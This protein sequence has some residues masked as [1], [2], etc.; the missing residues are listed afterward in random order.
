MI[1]P[2]QDSSCCLFAFSIILL[3]TAALATTETLSSSGG[4]F[5]L[6]PG[7]AEPEPIP[8]TEINTS[9]LDGSQSQ[10]SALLL[11]NGRND[12]VTN[13]IPPLN[14]PLPDIFP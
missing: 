2:T 6:F 11:D 10:E 1:L 3:S 9:L 8:E 14:I 7:S 13:V 12:G 5:G 4:Q